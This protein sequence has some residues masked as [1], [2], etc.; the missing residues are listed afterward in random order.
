MWMSWPQA[1]MTP[2][3]AGPVGGGR[4]AGVGES[5]GLG[6]GQCIQVRSDEDRRP[7]AVLEHSHH[8][9]L[10]HARRHLGT[11]L[12]QFVGDPGGRGNLFVGKLG[13]AVEVAIE[14]R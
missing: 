8:A 14:C 12:F 1:C 10:T 5:G 11:A 6:H 7:L 4:L 3:A 9:K 13:M 2:T